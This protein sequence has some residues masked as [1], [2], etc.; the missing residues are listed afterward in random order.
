MAQNVIREKLCQWNSAQDRRQETGDKLHLA[1]ARF[2]S[3]ENDRNT[4]ELC[5]ECAELPRFR[6]VLKLSMG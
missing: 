5:E 2:L 1:R 3:Y 6:Y 4:V